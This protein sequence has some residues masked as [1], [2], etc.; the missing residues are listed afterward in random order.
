MPLFHLQNF[1]SGVEHSWLTILAHVRSGLA[2]PSNYP[3]MHGCQVL[4]GTNRSLCSFK[5]QG[6]ADWKQFAC[7]ALIENDH[8]N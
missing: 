3:S 6:F 5:L 1:A 4:S 8:Y 7:I 2:A